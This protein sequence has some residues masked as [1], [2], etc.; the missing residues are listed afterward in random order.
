MS[1]IDSII[2][3]FPEG[4]VVTDIPNSKEYMN[5]YNIL[6]GMGYK[7][8][9]DM[10]EEYFTNYPWIVRFEGE[11]HG[12]SKRH[13]AKKKIHYLDFLAIIEGTNDDVDWKDKL[14]EEFEKKIKL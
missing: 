4:T 5:V 9:G 11:I 6:V 10:S 12:A 3:F 8:W 1:K 13:A 14:S 2:D 7:G